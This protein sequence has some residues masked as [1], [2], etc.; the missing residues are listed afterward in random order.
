MESQSKHRE[1][2]LSQFFKNAWRVK[3]RECLFGL[4]VVTCLF[5]LV[6][7]SMPM[8]YQAS[9][10]MFAQT[11]RKGQSSQSATVG[12]P[13]M[14]RL[15]FIASQ[16][17]LLNSYPLYLKVRR[18]FT[19][20]SWPLQDTTKK[21][22]DSVQ[23]I[24]NTLSLRKNLSRLI[25][26]KDYEED[27]LEWNDKD[28]T[29]FVKGLSFE[30]KPST[31]TFTLAFS[32]PNPRVALRMTRVIADSLIELNYDITNKKKSNLTQY[33]Q[34]KRTEAQAKVDSL[35]N[36]ISQFLTENNFSDQ[37]RVIEGK[38]NQYNQMVD[39]YTQELKDKEADEIES[40]MANE[41]VEKI[42][43]LVQKD[44][45]SGNDQKLQSLLSEL[46]AIQTQKLRREAALG[47]Q[48]S[49]YDSDI[50][51]IKKQIDVSVKEGISIGFE[52]KNKLL[53]QVRE[54]QREREINLAKRI[55]RFKITKQLKSAYE[56]EIKRYPE[57][58]YKLS[59]LTFDYQQ[60]LKSLQLISE[61]LVATNIQGD[62]ELTQLFS[63][64]EPLIANPTLQKG[65]KL[66]IGILLVS[67]FFL[68]TFGLFHFIN[69]TIFSRY[70]L[71]FP[72]LP[73]H[74]FLGA[75]PYRRISQD[76]RLTRH[77]GMNEAIFRDA[78]AL[79]L[80]LGVDQESRKGTVIQFWS[81]KQGSGK[82]ITTFAMA[83]ALKDLGHSVVVLDCDFSS[84]GGG[85]LQYAAKEKNRRHISVQN[86]LEGILQFLESPENETSDFLS[87]VV[88]TSPIS[89]GTNQKEAY[90]YF[91]GSFERD[92]EILKKH[93]EFILLDAPPLSE[94][95]A[96]LTVP[97][98]DAVILCCPEGNMT[99]R[100]Y[101]E[102][103]HYLES[104][105]TEKTKILSLFTL[106][107]LPMN[108][109]A[110]E[111]GVRERNFQRRVKIAA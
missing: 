102:L 49:Y 106:S 42:E 87:K 82:S 68:I 80:H 90:L 44:L 110:M 50:E 98:A 41:Y 58:Q 6:M 36:S 11:S 15:T 55:S 72:N 70:D 48:T 103:L 54:M 107:Q 7:R 18:A 29:Q 9:I 92:L 81:E 74:Y 26:G 75:I 3:W 33:L 89:A 21:S 57:L 111:L 53:S 88:I 10:R 83:L 104:Y 76:G 51:R 20:E 77:F 100:S 14:E 59:A 105:C 95:Q 109:E 67:I 60:A 8:N 79:K 37:D 22:E 12:M 34:E 39:L 86:N 84:R 2:P 47:K 46:S 38:I 23:K 73:K 65:L 13:E 93:Y 94:G 66:V 30:Q 97:R 4:C 1:Q 19:N 45:S 40:R 35:R 99:Q 16:E 5:V 69:G 78:Q 63:I 62:S 25:F 85:L 101:A 43:A 24:R 52:D 96:L 64:Q 27:S 108:R 17:E 91:D 32:H 61:S 28:Y 71:L 31:G 56:S